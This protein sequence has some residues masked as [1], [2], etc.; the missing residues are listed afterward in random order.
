MNALAYIPL[1]PDEGYSQAYGTVSA[2]H[3]RL[4]KP[5]DFEMAAMA[6]DVRE[7]LA[8]FDNTEYAEELSS[9]KG[10]ENRGELDRAVERHFQR[11]YGEATGAVPEYDRESID[12]IILGEYDLKNFKTILRGVK[13]SVSPHDITLM[14]SY[15]AIDHSTLEKMAQSNDAG[16]AFSTMTT[17]LGDT[18]EM[19]ET[20]LKEYRKMH[21][22]LP[23]EMT[24]DR[25]FVGRWL[26]GGR[27]SEYAKMRLDA[28]NLVNLFRCRTHRMDYRRH[29]IASGLYLDERMLKDIAET[30][31]AEIQ[32]YLETTPYGP[33]I[34]KA[35]KAGGR[36]NL[37]DLERALD[38]AIGEETAVNA[39]IR[40]LS[41]WPVVD[42][43]NLKQREARNVR[44]VLLL[45]AYGI[46]PERITKI[47]KTGY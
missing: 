32:S 28:T 15:G 12:R 31:A 16:E 9:V 25:M 7:A 5:E 26:A 29:V 19:P 33:A 17:A 8:F 30:P 1:E 21:S 34:K 24:L 14:L 44:T 11:A 39:I 37:L 41:I 36:I 47:L 22:I 27:L 13:N 40:P 2:M 42:F 45:K 23:L 3:S 38:D 4:L 6:G 18:S 46:K 20:A 35:A 10:H 43:I